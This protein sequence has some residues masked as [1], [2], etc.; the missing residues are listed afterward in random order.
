MNYYPHHIGDYTKN[1]V[2]ISMLEDGAYRRL[3]DLY[4]TRE[5]PLPLDMQM[6]YRLARARTKQERVAID[7][8]LQEFFINTELGFLHSR[9]E[10]EISNAQSRISAAQKNGAKGGRPKGQGL[11]GDHAS[12]EN[13]PL[14]SDS[15]PIGLSVGYENV[16][17]E[18]AHQSHKPKANPINQKPKE[19]KTRAPLS[20]NPPSFEDVLSIFDYFSEENRGLF[21]SYTEARKFFFHYDGGGWLIKGN[22]AYSLKSLVGS[23]LTKMDDFP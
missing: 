22:E 21:D 6:V 3:L 8:V 17:Q 1:T 23:W 18:K 14:G 7:A 10:K 15:N 19:Y 4:Y 13:N 16:T 11:E 2:H 12:E 5:K 20:E 9:C